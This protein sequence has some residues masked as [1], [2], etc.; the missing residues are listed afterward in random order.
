[1]NLQCPNCSSED[2]Q[3]LSLVM[4]KGGLFAKILRFG[5]I[6]AYNIW[7]PLVSVLSSIAFGFLFAMINVFL[8]LLVFFGILF[9]GYSA[10]KWIKAKSKSKYAEVPV[11]MKQN[12]FQCNRCEH[13]F[14]PAT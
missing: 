7:I 6:Y 3:K 11:Q 5:V 2:T 14:I 8:G 10:R 1:M 9:A 12:G 4:I 13:L